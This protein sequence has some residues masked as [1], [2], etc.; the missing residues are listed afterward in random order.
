MARALFAGHVAATVGSY[1]TVY[2]MAADATG[3]L[4]N[5][6]AYNS[7]VGASAVTV[8]IVE[9]DGT[10]TVVEVATIGAGASKSYFETICPQTLLEGNRV[11]AQATVTGVTL[12]ASGIV[13]S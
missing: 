8:G 12:R 4:Q 13:F 2:Q 5:L 7:G 6:T 3:R 9:S 1:A 10:T 11:V